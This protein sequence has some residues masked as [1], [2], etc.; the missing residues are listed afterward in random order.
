[1]ARI[2]A[3]NLDGKFFH[4]AGGRR[5]LEPF[6]IAVRSVKRGTPGVPRLM[7]SDHTVGHRILIKNQNG[8]VWTVA[9]SSERRFSPLACSQFSRACSSR[10][11]ILLKK[12][13]RVS[14][15]RAFP[16]STWRA[17]R[18]CGWIS[19]AAKVGGTSKREPCLRAGFRC[20][21]TRAKTSRRRP[22]AR[23]GSR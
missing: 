16:Y 20:R 9:H 11:N 12:Q 5:E 17:N 13:D 19:R 21:C 18:C 10:R 14:Q 23:F 22:T 4:H 15:G 2:A 1:M 3:P 8:G 7:A 6:A